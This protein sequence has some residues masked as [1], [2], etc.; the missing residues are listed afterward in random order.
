MGH[1][2]KA[3]WIHG[4]LCVSVRPWVWAQVDHQHAQQHEDECFYV[5]TGGVGGLSM[6]L[7]GRSVP[8]AGR[9]KLR[10]RSATT[11]S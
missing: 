4:L 11:A 9:W 3:A 10:H 8:G 6:A 7:L 1:Q 2:R 5:G